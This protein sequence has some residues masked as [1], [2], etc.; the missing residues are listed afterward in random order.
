MHH[1]IAVL[2][3]RFDYVNKAMMQNLWNETAG[4]F[5]VLLIDWILPGGRSQLAVAQKHA[6]CKHATAFAHF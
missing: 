1:A 6:L 4:Y 2:Q 5:Q 3:T